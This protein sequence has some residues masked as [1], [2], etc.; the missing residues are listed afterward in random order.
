MV[1]CGCICAGVSMYAW[2]GGDRWM[3][4]AMLM[5]WVWYVGNIVLSLSEGYLDLGV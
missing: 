3:L 1:V 4:K 2:K 5:G